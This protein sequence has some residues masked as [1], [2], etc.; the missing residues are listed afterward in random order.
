MKFTNLIGN[1]AKKQSIDNYIT[2]IVK[3]IDYRERYMVEIREGLTIRARNA[4][5]QDIIIGDAV[6]VR[7]IGGNINKAEIA[8]KSTRMIG[9]E[10]SVFWR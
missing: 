8:G 3:K 4:S 1:I 10:G 5:G 9:G 6:A 7:L 2:G